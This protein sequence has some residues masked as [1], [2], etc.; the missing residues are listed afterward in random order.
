MVEEL[1]LLLLSRAQSNIT[2]LTWYVLRWTTS[3]TLHTANQS[4]LEE[5][6]SQNLPVRIG[7]TRTQRSPSHCLLTNA[8]PL[9]LNSGREARV[10]E[11]TVVTLVEATPIKCVSVDA[12]LCLS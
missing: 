6:L 10:W 7:Y 11:R 2:Q 3:Y 5:V 9:P 1:I 4:S 8:L 12:F